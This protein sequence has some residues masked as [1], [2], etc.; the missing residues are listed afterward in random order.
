MPTGIEMEVELRGTSALTEVHRRQL[1]AAGLSLSL[2]LSLSL[3]LSLSLCLSLSTSRLFERGY[4][5]CAN[6]A[7]AY[8]GPTGPQDSQEIGP[9][10]HM[11]SNIVHL[12]R[13]MS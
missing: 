12:P 1:R 5:A 2:S 9:S 6:K 10:S 11:L 4:S 7:A 13:H 8:P 3:F